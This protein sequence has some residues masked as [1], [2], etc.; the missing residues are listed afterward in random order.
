MYFFRR[1][2]LF[3]GFWFRGG[4]TKRLLFLLLLSGGAG[5]GEV[6]NILGKVGFPFLPSPG[7]GE[8]K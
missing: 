5:I 4:L 6:M 2:N 1:P 8:E 3:W 7:G